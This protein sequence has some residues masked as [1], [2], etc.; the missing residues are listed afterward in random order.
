MDFL[1]DY[2]CTKAMNEEENVMLNMFCANPEDQNK[3]PFDELN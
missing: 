3:R 1:V 2:F